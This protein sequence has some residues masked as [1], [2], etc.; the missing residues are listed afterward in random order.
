MNKGLLGTNGDASSMR[1]NLVLAA[2]GAFII[3]LCLGAYIIIA[4]FKGTAPDWSTM[5]VFA[6]GIAAI[7]TGVGYTK[8]KQKEV[9]MKK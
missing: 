7:L 3:M 8:Y 6:A 2:I 5:G 1:F 9:E 4:A